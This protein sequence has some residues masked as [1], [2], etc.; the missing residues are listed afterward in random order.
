MSDSDWVDDE[1]DWA[2]DDGHASPEGMSTGVAQ[3]A[4]EGFGNGASMGYLPQL[5]ASAEVATDAIGNAKD[6]ALKAVGLDHLSSIDSQLRDQGFQLPDETYLAIRDANIKRQ[7]EQARIN[8]NTSMASN[9]AGMI[10]SGIATSGLGGS[11]AAAPTLLGRVAQGIKAGSKAGAIYGGVA[12]PGDVEG[13]LSPIQP[14]ERA[15]NAAFGSVT[16]GLVGGAAPLVDSGVRAVANGSRDYAERFAAR[17]LG[18]ERG[19]I[20]SLGFDKVKAAGRQALDEGVLST[21]ASTDDLVTRNAALKEK[22]G[23]M[24]GTAYGAIDDAGAST[25]NPLDAATDVEGKIGDFYRSPINRGETNQ[26]ENTLESILMRGDKNIPLREAQSLKQELGK[27]ANW[28]NNLN[29]TP[30]EQ[31]ARDAYFVISDHIDDAVSN[32]SKLIDKAGLSET[33]SQGKALFT[34]ASTADKLLDNKLAREQGNKLLGITDWGVLGAGGAASVATGG[35]AAVPTIA[36]LGAKKGLEKFGSQNA[37]L[38]LDK[39]SKILMKSPKMADLAQK[40]PMAFAG[41]VQ[42]MTGK[43]SPGDS[44]KE[45]ISKFEPES[46]IQKTQGTKYA[47]VLQD[48][49]QRGPEAVRA[50]NFVLQGRDPEY[51]K[52]TIDDDDRHQDGEEPEDDG[53]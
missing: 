41:L 27:V 51:R 25:F 15:K 1:N 10:T 5:Q 38:G 37:A 35:A 32:G 29:I 17:A 46:L 12:N 34:N 30:K 18:A 48:A 23:E 8:P 22:G 42:K 44:H 19:S 52:L 33:L 20:K 39:V 50:A 7:K 31:M 13:E 26:L 2:D 28:K 4:L 21:F 47:A 11:A 3:T 6:R 16:G 24:M 36:L 14:M 53:A 43:L 9:A 45:Q 40:N 49:M